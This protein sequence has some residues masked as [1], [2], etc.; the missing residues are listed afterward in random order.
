MRLG[1]LHLACRFCGGRGWVGED[2]EPAERGQECEPP[3]L[4]AVWEHKVWSDP[5]VAATLACRYCLGSRRVVHVADG[6]MT[7]TPCPVCAGAPT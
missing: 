4:P 7:A 2:N 1:S 5:S 6:R 3:P